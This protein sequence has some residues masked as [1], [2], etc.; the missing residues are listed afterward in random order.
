ML[1]STAISLALSLIL[2]SFV[3]LII[4]SN[5]PIE[6]M[7]AMMSMLQMMSYLTL[8]NLSFPPNLLIFFDCL[9]SV[10]NFNGWMPNIFAYVL[11]IKDLDLQPFNVQFED[12][13]FINRN[14]LFLC[15]PD[16][17]SLLISLVTIGVL[18]PLAKMAAY[19][20]VRDE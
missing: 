9:E 13:G 1:T 20:C 5:T 2:Y 16:F 6:G 3:V 12:R 8:I 19:N 4:N 11:N 10:H 7:W 14:L 18:L 17:M 15:G